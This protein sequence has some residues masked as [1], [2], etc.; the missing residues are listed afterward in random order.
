MQIYSL[1]IT[2]LFTIL[3]ML[4]TGLQMASNKYDNT[5]IAFILSLLGILSIIFQSIKL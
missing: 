1:I 2:I 3:F 5:L 4:S